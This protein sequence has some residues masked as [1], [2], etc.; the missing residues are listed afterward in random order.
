MIKKVRKELTMDYIISLF[1]YLGSFSVS[2]AFAAMYQYKVKKSTYG[3]FKHIHRFF[4]HLLII[5]PPVFVSTVRYGVGTDYFR[6]LIHIE[7][8]NSLPFDIAFNIYNKE[9]LYFFIQKV[10]VMLFDHGSGWGFFFISSFLIHYIIIV[11]IDLYKDKISMSFALFIY[12]L[13]LFSFGLNGIAQM[14]AIAVI[15]YSI[16]YILERKLVKFIIFVILAT[17]IHRSA[18]VCLVF[19]FVNIKNDK[20]ILKSILN[21]AYYGVI[22]LSPIILVFAI[23]LFDGLEFLSSYSELIKTDGVSLKVGFLFYILPIFIPVLLF[24]KQMTNNSIENQKIFDLMLMNIP[25]QYVGY[26]ITWGSRMAYYTNSI[27]F[28][29]IPLMLRS[30]KN[31]NDKLLISAYYVMYFLLFYAHKYIYIASSEVF[32]YK[33]IFGL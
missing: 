12:Y 21:F 17:L 26:Y 9:P 20:K 28:I 16:K 19:Y 6:Y 2:M 25:F 27:Y 4:W 11:S 3:G 29:A 30:L 5:A 33:T 7:K 24:R 1:I 23:N 18:I 14:I 15:L 31:R 32:P 8:I 22:I 10:S 13:Y